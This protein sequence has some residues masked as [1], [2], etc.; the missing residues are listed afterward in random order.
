V[1]LPHAAPATL[2]WAWSRATPLA[3]RAHSLNLIRDFN[4]GLMELG[5]TVCTPAPS[6]PKCDQCPIARCC[7][8]RALGLQ[9]QIPSPK[10]AARRTHLRHAVVLLRDRQGRYLLEQRGTT[11]IW[12]NLWQFAT[13]EL[14]NG[15]ANAA[16][17]DGAEVTRA[18]IA[19]IRTALGLSASVRL[20]VHPTIAPFSRTLSHRIVHFVVLVASAPMPARDLAS[21]ARANPRRALRALSDLADLP[22]A[23]PHRMI[24]DAL[25]DALDAAPT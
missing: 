19:R 13:V 16:T 25:A 18:D 23:T 9:A 3:H 6:T 15:G 10:A 11:S 4:E 2:E 21:L 14:A 22:L 24:A 8:A 17:A 1:Q 12:A 20:G 5:A 7:A